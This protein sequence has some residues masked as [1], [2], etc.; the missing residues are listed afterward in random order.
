MYPVKSEIPLFLLKNRNLLFSKSIVIFLWGKQDIII[1]G[2]YLHLCVFISKLSIQTEH[3]LLVSLNILYLLTLLIKFT[4][5]CFFS[6]KWSF[7]IYNIPLKH[8][9]S[10]EKRIPFQQA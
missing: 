10:N 2:V 7:Q 5:V 8:S 4:I 6:T 1:R 9:K 3:I